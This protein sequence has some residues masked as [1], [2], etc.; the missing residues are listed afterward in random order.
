MTCGC[1]HR[2]QVEVET[3]VEA[4]LARPKKRKN[5][6]HTLFVETGKEIT[7]KILM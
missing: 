2:Q 7:V 5:N 4:L 6:W 1:D 3:K